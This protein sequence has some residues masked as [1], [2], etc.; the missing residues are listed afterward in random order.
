VRLLAGVL[1]RVDLFLGHDSGVAHLSAL[2]GTPTVAMFGPTDPARW[3]PRGPAVTVIRKRPCDCASWD[4]V[5]NCGEKPCLELS[6]EA[7]VAACLSTG[8]IPI[9]PRIC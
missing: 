5:K 9:T 1:S 6:A 4:A 3:A 7:I 8:A 2:V